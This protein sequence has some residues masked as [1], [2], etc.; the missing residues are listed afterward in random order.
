MPGRSV[1]AAV[2]LLAPGSVVEA[3]TRDNNTTGT[4]TDAK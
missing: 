2:M 4:S 3:G 1:L